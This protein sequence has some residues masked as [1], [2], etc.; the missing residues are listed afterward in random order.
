MVAALQ[1]E[2]EDQVDEMEEEVSIKAFRQSRDSKED[3]DGRKSPWWTSEEAAN[4]AKEALEHAR[5]KKNKQAEVR[6][7]AL[8]NSVSLAAVKRPLKEESEESS[9]SSDESSYDEDDIEASEVGREIKSEP[10]SKGKSLSKEPPRSTL[11]LEPRTERTMTTEKR[12]IPIKKDPVTKMTKEE[13][14]KSTIAFVQRRSQ[15]RF[16]AMWMRHIPTSFEDFQQ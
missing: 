11:R 7:K 1:E 4:Q 15:Q 12:T 10:Q 13:L 6:I 2:K 14:E 5:I 16:K 9:Y 3:H 8:R